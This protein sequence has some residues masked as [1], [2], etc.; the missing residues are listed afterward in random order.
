MAIECQCGVGVIVAC[1]ADGYRVSVWSG[2]GRQ[3]RVG[4][5]VA[6][7]ADG[8]R[9]SVRGGGDSRLGG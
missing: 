7:V 4:M 5:I 9:V 8:Y 3:C 2:S 1:G 6:F